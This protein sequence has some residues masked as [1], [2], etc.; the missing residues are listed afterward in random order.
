MGRDFQGGRT[1][2]TRAE[3]LAM[4]HLHEEEFQELARQVL[5]RR[6]EV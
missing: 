3:V 2:L 1:L 6:E 4:L 5:V